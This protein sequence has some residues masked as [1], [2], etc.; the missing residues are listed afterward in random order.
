MF[1]LEYQ[2][3]K[4][5]N[6]EGLQ[7]RF[8]RHIEGAEIVRAWARKHFEIF[9]NENYMS[10]TLTNIKNTRN[11]D[12]AALNKAL[13]ERGFQISNGYGKL[14][15]KTFRIAHMAERTPEELKELLANIDEILGF[16]D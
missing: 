1:A 4:I 12:I 16:E 9:P 3:D 6:Q 2:L 15:D 7:N 10:N 13:G 8:D 14:K 11:I 5:I